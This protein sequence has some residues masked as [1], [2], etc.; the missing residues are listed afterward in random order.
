MVQ[1]ST[2]EHTLVGDLLECLAIAIDQTAE[3]DPEYANKTK[4]QKLLYLAIDEFDLPL[5]YSWYLAGAIV[6]GDP[7][8]PTGL[9]TQSITSTA[10]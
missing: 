3:V 7:V 10:A 6:P 5:T 1:L 9:Q 4:L 8:S 2:A